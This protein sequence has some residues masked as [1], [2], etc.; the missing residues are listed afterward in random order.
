MRIIRFVTALLLLGTL[1]GCGITNPSDLTMEPPFTGSI[2]PG[3]TSA[4]GLS[5]PTANFSTG[6]TGEFIVTVTSV[7]PD[8]GASI[9]VQY[10]QESA[11]LCGIDAQVTS[12]QGATAFDFQLPKGDDYC[13]QVYDAGFLPRTETFSIA[14]SHP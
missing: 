8:S 5:L 4:S 13:V 3:E 12:G 10:G 9:G 14:I 1:A 6:K 2:S 7:S 11:G